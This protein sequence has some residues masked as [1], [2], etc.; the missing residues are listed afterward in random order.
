MSN[1]EPLCG[2]LDGFT[3]ARFLVFYYLP[4]GFLTVGQE[5]HIGRNIQSRE[6]FDKRYL[7]KCKIMC[8]LICAAG[9]FQRAKYFIAQHL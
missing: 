3:L 4:I 5:R 1:P 7:A 6:G 2:A 8:Y 9:T